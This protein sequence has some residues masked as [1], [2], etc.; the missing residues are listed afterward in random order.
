MKLA[1]APVQ[2]F[3]PR[4]RLAEFYAAVAETP[5]DTVYLGEQAPM[6]LGESPQAYAESAQR[7]STMTHKPPKPN[8]SI[9]TGVLRATCST[10]AADSTRGSTARRTPN[11][12]W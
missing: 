1:L 8:T 3:W 9:S 10:C 6:V 12:S 2:Y 4:V 7:P 5:V 11:C